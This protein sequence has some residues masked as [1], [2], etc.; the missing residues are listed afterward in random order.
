[1][2]NKVAALIVA[3]GFSK[4]FGSDKLMIE[5]NG[6]PILKRTVDVFHRM[7]S[8]SQIIVVVNAKRLNRYRLLFKKWEMENVKTVEGGKK[9][10]W[11]SVENG[12]NALDPSIG[13]VVIHDGARPLVSKDVIEKSI[14]GAIRFGAVVVGYP[15]TDTM[16][17]VDGDIIARTLD[18][19]RTFAV[20]TPQAFKVDLLRKA[21]K[22]V[23]STTGFS[24]ITDDASLVERTGKDVH[25]IEGSKDNIKITY[26]QDVKRMEHMIGKKEIK[27]DT[28][29]RTGFGYDIHRFDPKRQLFLGGVP[30]PGDGLSGHSDADVVLHAL[31]DAILGAIGERDIGYHFPPN[32]DKFKDAKSILFIDKALNLAQKSGWKVSNVDITMIAERPRM[33]KYIDMIKDKLSDMLGVEKERIS[34]KARTNEGLGP[35]GEGKGIAALATVMMVSD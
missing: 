34:V 26:P 3:G 24:G 2:K 12:L 19:S 22:H 29:F 17:D 5:L 18:R 23:R 10:R 6:E 4:R 25:I 15:S 9:D 16:K 13:I 30:V 14:D 31:T 8:F 33:T 20:Q 35:I 32:D 27:H 21:Y 28:E 7:K 1:M 11:E